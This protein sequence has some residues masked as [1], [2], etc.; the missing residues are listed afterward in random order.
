MLALVALDALDDDFGGGA[1]LGLARF[2]GLGFGGFLLG[3]FFGA[4]LG[5]D[6]ER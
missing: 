5:V 6:A 1:L 4:L 3:V 2:G